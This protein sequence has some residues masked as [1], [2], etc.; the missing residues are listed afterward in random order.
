MTQDDI[1]FEIEFSYRA[2]MIPPVF[3]DKGRIRLSIQD[4]GFSADVEV[5][6]G[7]NGKPV[8]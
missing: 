3:A 5:D 6:T 8:V 7:V 4:L 2:Y 1:D